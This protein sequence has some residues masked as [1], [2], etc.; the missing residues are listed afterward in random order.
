MVLC[1]LSCYIARQDKLQMCSE[2]LNWMEPV[3]FNTKLIFSYRLWLL[4]SLACTGYAEITGS[5]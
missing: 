5:K 4:F 2:E 3:N 1:R